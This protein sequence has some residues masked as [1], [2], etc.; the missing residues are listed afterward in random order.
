MELTRSESERM[1]S[2][3]DGL[4]KCGSDR[5]RIELLGCDP[6]VA[7]WLSIYNERYTSLSQEHELVLASLIAIGQAERLLKSE[8]PITALL[9]ELLPIEAF[10]KELGGIVGYHWK[11]FSL[12]S[13][14]KQPEQDDKYYHSPPVVDISSENE[15]TQ[16]YVLEALVS[17]SLF[18]EIYPVGGA[19]D[20]LKLFAPE[21]GEPLP[22]AKL[23]FCGFSLLEGLIRDV[24]AREYL[25][26]KLF[27]KQSITPIAMMTSSEKDNHR[28]ILSLCEERN[29]FGR[30]KDSFRFFCQPVVP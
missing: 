18:A 17:L 5:E 25:H 21:T 1:T 15:T 7:D 10:Y 16:Q 19:A 30:P 2:L 20:R 4:K 29:W 28:H 9:E 24:Q 13:Q 26:F 22:A 3:I 23:V 12:L 27:G 11:L 8:E 6:H 14:E